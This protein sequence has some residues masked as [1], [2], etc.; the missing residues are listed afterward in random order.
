MTV[1]V[2]ATGHNGA[3]TITTGSGNDIIEGDDGADVLTGGAGDDTYVYRQDADLAVGESITEGLG[4]GTD[5]IRTYGS[6]S[7]ALLSS[8]S[9][10]NVEQVL[11][12]SGSTATFTGA[13][14]TGKSI[15]VN[16]TSEGATSLAVSVAA[17]STVNLSQLQFTAFGGN[18]AFGTSD[19]VVI[20]SAVG[21]TNESITG[22]S[23]ADTINAGDGADTINGGAGNDTL[24]L[25]A[26]A[27]TDTVVFA[28]T[29]ANNGSDTISNFT[30]GAGGDVLNFSA[31]ITGGI[32]T[33]DSVDADTYFEVGEDTSNVD[34][35]GQL[36]V[37][38]GTL[39]SL[40]EASEIAALFAG[41]GSMFANTLTGNKAIVHAGSTGSGSS[42]IWYVNDT[43]A[44]GVSAA[45][46]QLVATVQ[47]GSGIMAYHASNYI[48][49]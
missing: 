32:N 26:D 3:D 14:L 39:T 19:S 43:G 17:G 21:N 38:G 41:G 24:N 16:E 29:A 33:N 6:V 22:T 28:N 8:T 1:A 20:T 4:G 18:T 48:V 13:H 5:T 47:T 9:L 2:T 12:Q 36:A 7:F 42:Y 15:V 27:A 45:D 11:L 49:A 25:G 31:F 35:G 10:D 37:V 40:D 44:D 23:V 46:I 34:I 30:S